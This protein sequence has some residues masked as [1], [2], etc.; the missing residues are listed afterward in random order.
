MLPA[1]LIAKKRDGGRLSEEEIQSLVDGFVRGDVADYQMAAMAMAICLRGMDAEETAALTTAMLHSGQ[2]LPRSENGPPRVDKHST[3][4]LGDKISLILAPLLATC[5]VQ[6]PMISGR[7]LGITGGTLDKLESIPGYSVQFELRDTP[8]LLQQAGCFIIGASL[9]IAP[10]DRRLYALRDVTGTVESVAL[11]TASIL[12]KKLAAS[13][14]ALVMDVKCG[15]GAFMHSLD[16]AQELAASLMSTGQAA[17]LPV[18]ALITD[19]EQPLGR[20]VGN[21]I[22]VNESLDVLAG[23]GPAEVRELTLQLAAEALV[24]TGVSV[25]PQAGYAL[26][27]THLDDGSARERFEQMVVAQGGSLKGPLPLH[28]AR[29]I[30]PQQAGTLAEIDC[31]AIGESIVALGG[32]RRQVGD[33]IDHR[34]GLDVRARIGD[35]VAPDQP[36]AF[37]H[38]SGDACGK[39]LPRLTAAFQIG[40]EA[41]EPRPLVLAH[42]NAEL[43]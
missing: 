39:V 9:Q 18:R 33:S 35:A 7:G 42:H 16:R 6:V 30:Y 25:D 36:L 32:G 38:C 3:G 11:I 43:S 17:G 13:L 10:A 41:V 26:A 21:A 2:C 14:D 1:S 5:G 29:P 27:A 4:G 20:A 23:A 12:S 34:V 15:N 8:S 24:M 28:Q 37:L 22:E 31:R 40:D 19:M